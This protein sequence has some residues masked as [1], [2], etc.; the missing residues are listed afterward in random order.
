MSFN[1]ITIG[2]GNSLSPARCQLFIRNN[3][4]I[5]LNEKQKTTFRESSFQTTKCV[6]TCHLKHDS[7]FVSTSVYIPECVFSLECVFCCVFCLEPFST[8]YKA[9]LTHISR[10]SEDIKGVLPAEISQDAVGI[11]A[12]IWSPPLCTSRNAYSLLN[13]YSVVYSVLDLFLPITKQHWCTSHADKRISRGFF[14]SR[15]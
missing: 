1:W 5:W 9:A 7:H 12:W 6:W 3:S 10:R 14:T 8:N 15:D 4:G 2:R 11:R 13:V